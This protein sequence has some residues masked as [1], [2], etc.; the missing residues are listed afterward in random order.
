MPDGVLMTIGITGSDGFVG[1]HVRCLLRARGLTPRLAPRDVFDDA[2]ALAAFV[3]GLDAVVH[4]AGV[5]RAPDAELFARNVAL[6]DSLV[7]ACEAT[8]ATPHVLFASSTHTERATPT[9]Y[10]EGKAEAAL[11]LAAWAG[12]AGGAVT[13]FVVPHVFGEYG[14][15]HYN[16][17]VATFAHQLAHREEP[18]V[19]QDAPLEQLHAQDLAEALVDAAGEGA[20]GATTKRLAGHPTTV[21]E[22]LDELR[23]MDATY[24]GGVIPSV[25]DPFRLRLFN[26]YRSFL[27]PDHYPVAVP[28][29]ADARGHLF[30]TVKAGSGGQCF[31]STTHPGI[32]RGN[33]FHRFKVE[34]FFVLS[35]TA[36]IRIRPVLE[37]EPREFVVSGDAPCYVDIPTLQTHNITNVGSGELVTL[38]WAHEFFDPERSDTYFEDV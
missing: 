36:S 15:P 3:D 30:E 20:S 32:T 17:A 37:A 8:G 33:H 11:R 29:H 21:V 6:A 23:G 2:A 27:Y 18:V 22:V 14:R 24:R 12:R 4:L 31:V 34:R 10:G 28:L 7:A 26:T 25:S 16:S 38:F 1:R 35:G 19:H 9:A 5:N 13:T